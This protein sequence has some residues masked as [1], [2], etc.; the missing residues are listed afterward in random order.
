MCFMLGLIF[1]IF[2][3]VLVICLSI[4]RTHCARLSPFSISITLVLSSPPT[5][6]SSSLL[7][8][9]ALSSNSGPLSQAQ[10]C[11]YCQSSPPLY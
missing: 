7:T 9:T 10:P 3:G 11:S 4:L 6:P 8:L 5:I 1:R 2:C